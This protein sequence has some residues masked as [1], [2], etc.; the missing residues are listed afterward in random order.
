M[1]NPIFSD[2]V[3]IN[4]TSSTLL[5]NTDIAEQLKVISELYNSGAL[6]KEEF[7]KAKKRILN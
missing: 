7:E 6:T 2:S 3:Q 5:V 4:N 1:I